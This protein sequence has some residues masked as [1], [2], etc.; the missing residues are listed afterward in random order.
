MGY[1]EIFGFHRGHKIYAEEDKDGVYAIWKYANDGTNIRSKDRQCPRCGNTPTKEGHDHC[2]ANLPGVDYACCGH[3]VE[4]G[5][6]KL[7]DDRGTIRFGTHLNKKEIIK[8]IED[9]GTK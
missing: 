6:V 8:L 2:I 9:H 7:S 5:Y 4:D 1:A 3:G